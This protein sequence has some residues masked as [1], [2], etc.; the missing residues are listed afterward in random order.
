MSIPLQNNQRDPKKSDR[1]QPTSSKESHTVPEKR[2]PAF[3]PSKP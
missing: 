1:L 3:D 2:Q